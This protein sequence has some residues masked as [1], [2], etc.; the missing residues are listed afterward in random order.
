MNL[1]IKTLNGKP[2]DHPYLEEN[3]KS[4]FPEMDLDNLPAGWAK[5]ER[6]PRPKLGVYETAEC[7]YEWDGDVVKDVWYIHQMGPE[8][9]AQKQERV[10]KSWVDDGGP[11]DWIF[12]EN[13]CCHVA[14][15]PYP[16]D[17]QIYIWVQAAGI[18]VKPKIETP[19]ADIQ[20]IPYPLDGKTYEFDSINKRWVEKS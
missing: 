13:R 11:S 4:A 1:Y 10:K 17:G 14:P 7:F 5:F 16:N 20:P 9:K 12:D 8:E 19:A 15:V 3:M 2:V 18:W 6:V